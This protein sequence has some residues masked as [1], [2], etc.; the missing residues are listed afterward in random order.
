MYYYRDKD[1]KEIDLLY[2]DQTNIYPIEIKKNV[3]PNKPTKNFNVLNKYGLNI[4]PGLV[5]NNCDK[6]R[7]INEAA[8]YYPIY[9]LGS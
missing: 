7:P 2:V 3:S 9:L 8:F 4:K 5:I 1:Q 6:I